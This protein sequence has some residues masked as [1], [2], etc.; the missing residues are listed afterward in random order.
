MFIQELQKDPRYFFAVVITVVVSICI[1]ELA[2]GIVAIWLGDRTP[3]ERGHMTLNPAVHL[4]VF[5]VICLLLAGIA[6]GAMPITPSR[7]RGRYAEALVAAAG[8]VSNVLLSIL[9]LGALGIWLRFDTRISDEMP[10]QL[11]NIRYLLWVFGAFN[12]LLAMFN[13]L[14]VPPLDGSAI[15]ANFSRAYAT[16]IQAFTMS[17]ASIVLFILVFTVAGNLLTPLAVKIGGR[18]LELVRGW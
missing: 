11:A 13:L 4:G 17:G 1:H 3:I 12:L 9:F 16:M 8:P 15:L 18:Y 14:P 7:L 5:S 10:M 2:H 6:W